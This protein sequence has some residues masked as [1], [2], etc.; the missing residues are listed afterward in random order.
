MGVM[1][2]GEKKDGGGRGQSEEEG[3]GYARLLQCMTDERLGVQQADRTGRHAWRI[4]AS[5]LETFPRP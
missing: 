3:R 1:Q 2:V 5:T 4:R